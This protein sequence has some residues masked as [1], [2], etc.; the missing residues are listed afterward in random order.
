MPSWKKIIQSG[1]DAHLSNIT[2]SG[3]VEA[4]SGSFSNITGSLDIS[5]ISQV[6]S[7]VT[8]SRDDVLM[9][10]GTEFV[11]VP[12]TH[13]F[14]FSIDTFSISGEGATT[15]IIGDD[16]DTWPSASSVSYNATYNNGPPSIE[17]F[18]G[19]QENS[20]SEFNFEYTTTLVNTGNTGTANE[21]SNI[22]FPTLGN[23]SAENARLHFKF[24]A[25][26][27]FFTTTTTINFRNL[28]LAGGTTSTDNASQAR[29]EALESQISILPSS[30]NDIEHS[31]TK[32]LSATQYLAIA[33]R[34][35]QTS[36]QL[37]QVFCGT[38]TN[39]ITVAMNP[40][41][42]TSRIAHTTATYENSAGKS[43]TFRYYRSKLQNLDAHSSTFTTEDSTTRPK[44]YIYWG[45]DGQSSDY[46]ASFF[47]AGTPGAS[48]G[49]DWDYYQRNSSF[50]DGNISNVT[51]TFTAFSDKFVII[52]YP[53]RY[54]LKN[55]KDQGNFDFGVNSPT[56]V[57]I[58]NPCGFT[59]DYYVYRSG[60]SLS[61]PAGNLEVTI[62]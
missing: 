20:T 22:T 2:A 51:L 17:S 42:A 30:N 49:D 45:Y 34:Q 26:G 9:F 50:D 25:D 39:K 40:S 28:F 48:A 57:A 46:D 29:I 44:N 55:F 37:K 32:S 24:K 7:N 21:S 5:N 43:E 58:T 41:D 11:A 23:T 4:S 61:Y 27:N 54:G 8:P 52:A 62:Q 14:E 36:N 12:P 6:A 33:H 47:S 53:T 3:T 19:I 60:N 1:S 13:T 10:N 59:E 31:F 56:T 18:V 35:G 15:Q 38:G 16:S